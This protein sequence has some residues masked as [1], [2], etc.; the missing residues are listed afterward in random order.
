[1]ASQ[2]PGPLDFAGAVEVEIRTRRPD[3]SPR[4][5]V[6]W[7][8]SDGSRLFVRSYRGAAGRW[9]QEALRQ[10]RAELA[11]GDEGPAP[12]GVRH[13]DDPATIDLVSRLFER[14]YAGDPSMP[15]MVGTDVLGTTLELVREDPG[16]RSA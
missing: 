14:K 16:V 10:G 3:G 7:T 12:F 2:R 9:Y 11:I 13:V 15:D 5:T 1:M 4:R 6:I 8:V